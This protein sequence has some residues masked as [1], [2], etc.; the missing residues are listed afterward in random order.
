MDVPIRYFLSNYLNILLYNYLNI[1]ILHSNNIM[2]AFVVRY[3]FSSERTIII[4][5]ITIIPRLN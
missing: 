3:R 2:Y 5:G 4:I 1:L